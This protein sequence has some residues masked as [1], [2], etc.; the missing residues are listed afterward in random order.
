MVG[1]DTMMADIIPVVMSMVLTAADMIFTVVPMAVDM[2]VSR[3]VDM[4]AAVM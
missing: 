1:T 3:A 2:A 4:A